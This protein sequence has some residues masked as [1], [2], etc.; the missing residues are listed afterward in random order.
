MLDVLIHP[1]DPAMRVDF[2]MIGLHGRNANKHAFFPFVR[3]MGFLHT[4]WILPSAPFEDERLHGAFAWFTKGG[5]PAREI[6]SAHAEITALIDGQ[7]RDGVLPENIFLVGFSQGA[8]MSLHVALR[9]PRR[10]GGVVALSGY[11]IDPDTLEAERNAANRTVPV[12]IGHGLRDDVIPIDT[13]RTDAARLLEMDVNLDYHEYDTAHRIP[14]AEVRD[15][16][17]FLHRHMY[18]ILP[19]DPRSRDDGLSPF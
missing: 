12:F 2:A 9:H 14:S 1:D 18:G 19:D 5:D 8:A 11:V 3:Q 6:A 15:I 17:A 10:L 4:R 7:I 16:R 13:A